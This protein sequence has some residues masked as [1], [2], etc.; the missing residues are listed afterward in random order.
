MDGWMERG[1]KDTRLAKAVAEPAV[2]VPP[3]L[4][5]RTT[6]VE[7]GAGGYPATAGGPRTVF[8]KDHAT[9]YKML[10]LGMLLMSVRC[11]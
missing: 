11:L 5:T 10:T 2:G 7:S 1:Y 3:P 9:G 4:I 8:T 6:L